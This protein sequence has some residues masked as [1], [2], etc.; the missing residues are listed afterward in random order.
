MDNLRLMALHPV[1][2]W[3]SSRGVSNTEEVKLIDVRDIQNL[4][5]LIGSNVTADTIDECEEIKWCAESWM[6]NEIGVGGG[7][8]KYGWA[9][10]D[11]D[12]GE[13]V[14]AVDVERKRIESKIKYLQ[15]KVLILNSELPPS[16]DAKAAA[17]LIAA[18]K[19]DAGSSSEVWALSRRMSSADCRNADRSIRHQIVL[20]RTAIGYTV[21]VQE[22][23]L[24]AC[25]NSLLGVIE[26]VSVETD[27]DE[28]VIKTSFSAEEIDRAIV[29]DVSKRSNSPI[30]GWKLILKE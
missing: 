1:K 14:V 10:I 7:C 27:Q 13:G 19:N 5:A 6:E 15:E 3:Y 28:T 11:P 22:G 29:I 17:D 9:A 4:T 12:S 18:V 24:R 30:D 25:P 16:A 23:H 20:V 8:R 21:T 2:F 26:W